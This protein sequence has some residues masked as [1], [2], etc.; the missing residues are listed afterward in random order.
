MGDRRAS[1]TQSPLRAER[2]HG[3]HC[4]TSLLFFVYVCVHVC[5]YEDWS[6]CLHVFLH[7]ESRGQ[8]SALVFFLGGGDVTSI[9]PLLKTRSLYSLEL[10]L[11]AR[12]AREPQNPSIHYSSAGITDKY[13]YYTLNFYV[14]SGEQ[15]W[16]FFLAR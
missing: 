15:T 14:D 8:L 4:N 3:L 5:V 12:L 10:T 6:T 7:M 11:Q 2:L 9:L 1:A 16:D 13:H